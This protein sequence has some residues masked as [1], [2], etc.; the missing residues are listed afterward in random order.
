MIKLK[1]IYCITPDNC[2]PIETELPLWL[3]AI[4]AG[5]TALLIKELI[6]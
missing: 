1:S 5:A 2:V 3:V 6:K 4:L